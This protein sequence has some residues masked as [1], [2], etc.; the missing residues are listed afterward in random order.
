MTDFIIN[1]I[2]E[3]GSYFSYAAVIVFLQSFYEPDIKWNKR[4]AISLA[5]IALIDF[6]LVMK[7]EDNILASLILILI[8]MVILVSDC[9]K[10]KVRKAIKI[11]I[12]QVAFM[13]AT[14]NATMTVSAF[15]TPNYDVDSL[16]LTL[17]EDVAVA[18]VY[19]LFFGSVF[20]YLRL[21]IT[22]KGL[23]I[24]VTKKESVL[25][26][27]YFFYV[28]LL[29]IVT[30]ICVENSVNDY[31]DALEVMLAFNTILL[32]TLLP[33]FIYHN[34]ISEFFRESTEYQKV[35]IE[36]ELKHFQQY[37]AN[38][39]ETKR[40]RH[41]MKNH[42][43]CINELLAQGKTE[44]GSKYLKSLMGEVQS[45]SQKY[46]SGDEMLDS[47]ISSKA[48]IM[49]KSS[50]DFTL[51]GVL[52]GGLNIDAV[53]VCS[54]F[55]NALDNAIEAN[56]IIGLKEKYVKMAL[57]ATNRLWL[58]QIQNPVVVDFDTKKLFNHGFTTKRDKKH[59]GI[60]TFNIKRAV[61]KYGGAVEAKCKNK[62]FTLDILLPKT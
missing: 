36:A 50:I 30:A 7:F 56:S 47:I 15:I 38:Q 10:K 11:M 42:L 1:I 13:L 51:E 28:I 6:I 8:T 59:H 54:I 29:F 4:K 57:K 22:G 35:Y 20:L 16:E 45:L 12:T 17:F 49:K 46:V 31:P 32:T 44:E 33:V 23:F 39:E 55:A 26:G 2:Y 34:R 19:L 21:R 43:V 60:G 25:I 3:I 37:K 5:I 53:D 52:A 40:F 14:T 41:D 61:E 9:G 18:V 62:I 58:I 48:D 27:F 24:P